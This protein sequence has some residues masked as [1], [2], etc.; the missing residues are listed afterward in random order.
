MYLMYGL[1]IGLLSVFV[2]TLVGFLFTRENPGRTLGI[3]FVVGLL[4]GFILFLAFW[5]SSQGF[6]GPAP[7]FVFVVLGAILGAIIAGASEETFTSAIPGVFVVVFLTGWAAI[8]GINGSNFFSSAEKARILPVEIKTLDAQILPLAD[9][10]HICLIDASMAY[11]KAEKAL[12][13]IKLADN[14]NAGSRYKL[15]DATKQFVNGQLWWIFPLDF[16]TYWQW[17]DDP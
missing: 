2:P 17:S 3:G 7:G 14:A 11:S 12:S 5:G 1:L 10:A 16:V 8:V 4:Y 13:Q 9:P 15:G 6:Y